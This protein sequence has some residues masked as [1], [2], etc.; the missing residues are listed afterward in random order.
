MKSKRQNLLGAILVLG[1]LGFLGGCGGGASSAR[2]TEDESVQVQAP[3]QATEA[4]QESS[5]STQGSRYKLEVTGGG[6]LRVAQVGDGHWEVAD[7]GNVFSATSQGG[8]VSLQE[9][10]KA[11]A[12]GKLKGDKLVLTGSSGEWVLKFKAEKTKFGRSQ[13]LTPLEFKIKED[14]IKVVLEEQ[15]LGK[16]QFYPDTGK[17]KVK[18]HDAAEI[19]VLK[20]LGRLS[21]APGVFLAEK[22]GFLSETDRNLLLVTLLALGK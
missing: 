9:G 20:G 11:F 18:D 8:Q 12:Q 2:E 5:D 21:A 15:E 6:V 7:K 10:G 1:T 17:L 16:V 22:Q 19:A 3:I 14:K 4:K 13:E